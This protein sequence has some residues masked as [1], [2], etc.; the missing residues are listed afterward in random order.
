MLC[1]QASCYAISHNRTRPGQA[2]P[3]QKLVHALYN[4]T[5]FQLALCYLCWHFHCL[6]GN[7]VVKSFPIS[8]GTFE[9]RHDK[10]NKMSV[11]PAKTQISL[12]IRS[13]WSE[14]SLCA[15]W[16]AKGP[17]CS[18]CGQRR[19]WSDR[20]NAQDLSESSLGAQPFCW[21]CHVPAHLWN[22]YH[23]SEIIKLH[24][25]Q[26]G[27]SRKYHI[28]ASFSNSKDLQQTAFYEQAYKSVFEL[29]SFINVQILLSE[30][31]FRRSK[32]E[33]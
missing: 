11:H 17:K 8:N 14:S 21:L 30:N 18:S 19:L 25:V 33:W 5:V 28:S 10:S 6:Y 2:R 22:A 20:A 27:T 7:K 32:F 31:L 12:G 26:S 9:P 13:V 4:I 29:F 15:Q 23:T 24:T 16:V 1:H 3:G